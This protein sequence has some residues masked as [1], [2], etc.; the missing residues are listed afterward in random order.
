MSDFDMDRQSYLA[1]LVS[2]NARL[3]IV[4]GDDTPL[5]DHGNFSLHEDDDDE[6]DETRADGF[7]NYNQEGLPLDNWHVRN[8]VLSRVD[9]KMDVAT[10]NRLRKT[11]RNQIR[12]VLS[13]SG[14]VTGTGGMMGRKAPQAQKP[15][16]FL[17]QPAGGD[18]PNKILN[19]SLKAV[20]DDII[21]AENS[22]PDYGF[23]LPDDELENP[24]QHATQQV[25]RYGHG[26]AQVRRPGPRSKTA[27]YMGDK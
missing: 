2:D 21:R 5:R 23:G 13:E 8:N 14:M 4:E 20:Y 25:N 19:T 22:P 1:G 11:I 16:H 9:V 27:G 3:L 15:Q 24:T 26:A 7:Y 10:E 6:S 18:N 12:S 17:T